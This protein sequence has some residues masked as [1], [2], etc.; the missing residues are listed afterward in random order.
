MG[1]GL[2]DIYSHSG[3]PGFEDRE[4]LES[5]MQAAAA[6]GFTRVAILPDTSPP[7]DNLAGLAL[8][9]QHIRNL[10]IG[11]APLVFLGSADSGR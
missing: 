8:L 6:G 5:L 11:L 10:P 9:Q 3:E 7:V 1:P 4:T 2:T